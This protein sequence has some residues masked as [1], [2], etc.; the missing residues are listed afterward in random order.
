MIIKNISGYEQ[1]FHL[2]GTKGVRLANNA[3]ATVIEDPVS[4]VNVARYK[5]KGLISIVS[6]SNAVLFA[7]PLNVPSHTA[8]TLSGKGV[9]GSTLKVGVAGG[10][11]VTFELYANG[12][13]PASVTAGNVAVEIGASYAI[14]TINGTNGLK[15]KINANAALAALGISVAG[16][17]TLTANGQGSAVVYLVRADNDL[18]TNWDMAGTGVISVEAAGVDG[19]DNTTKSM[20]IVT[21]TVSGTPAVLTVYTGLKSIDAVLYKVTTSAGVVVVPTGDTLSTD[22]GIVRIDPV[23]AT[24]SDGDIVTVYAKGTPN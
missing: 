22:G 4:L 5:A 12:G 3:E 10:S 16:V 14:D 9:A 21:Q 20:V 1:Y 13:D 2:S 17:A 15:A 23:G 6:P 8:V 24:F 19:T 11:S 7:A 18:A